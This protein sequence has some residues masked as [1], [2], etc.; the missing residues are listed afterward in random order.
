MASDVSFANAAGISPVNLFEDSQ[1]PARATASTT[2]PPSCCCTAHGHKGLSAAT[3]ALR[4]RIYEDK[5]RYRAISFYSF[6][7]LSVAVVF[8][9]SS[10]HICREKALAAARLFHVT[11]FVSGFDPDSFRAGQF[12][13][14][15]VCSS[16]YIY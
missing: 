9:R 16:V 13:P 12:D 5:L 2:S 10:R 11:G 14:E 6:F 1:F 8:L 15:A 3:L 7:T 4:V